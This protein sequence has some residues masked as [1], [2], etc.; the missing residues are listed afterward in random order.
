MRA[1]WSVTNPYRERRKTS[2][3]LLEDDDED[4]SVGGFHFFSWQMK[5]KQTKQPS[6]HWINISAHRAANGRLNTY[7]IVMRKT[8]R[9]SCSG[10]CPKGKHE[11]IFDICIIGIPRFCYPMQDIGLKSTQ[12]YD[13]WSHEN[14]S[15]LSLSFIRLPTRA[16]R[17]FDWWRP[18]FKPFQA[19]QGI[20]PIWLPED[21]KD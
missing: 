6:C 19:F 5:P 18:T 15:H 4:L 3:W 16:I 8:G 12:L 7:R 13:T 21:V 1:L 17:W 20:G 14:S 2:I 9:C 10:G 11:S